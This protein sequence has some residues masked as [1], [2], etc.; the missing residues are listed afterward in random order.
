M[1]A[2]RAIGATR[3][4]D[5]SSG[6]SLRPRLRLPGRRTDRGRQG[7]CLIWRPALRLFNPPAPRPQR[8]VR[9]IAGMAGIISFHSGEDR[10][11]K[12]FLAQKAEGCTCPPRLPVCVCGN[13]PE[14]ELLTRKAIA[15][16]A[17]EVASNPRSA[18]ARLRGA[19]KL[20]PLA[21]DQESV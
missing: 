14:A 5:P 9:A 19:R 18:S 8:I 3:L 11:V 12:R 1:A 13:T 7:G 21:I 16:T 20:S 6:W 2:S 17:G 15:P 10:R 4:D